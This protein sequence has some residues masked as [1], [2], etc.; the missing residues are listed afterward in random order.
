VIW[1]EG[2]VSPT[3]KPEIGNPEIVK[4]SQE[5]RRFNPETVVIPAGGKVTFPNLDP[6]FHNVFSLSKPK[7]VRSGQLSQRRD[8]NGNVS[9]SRHCVCE[10]PSA[11]RT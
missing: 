1:L 10:L 3:S 11:I 8:A 5:N 9:R 2:R 7:N 4:M 6:I